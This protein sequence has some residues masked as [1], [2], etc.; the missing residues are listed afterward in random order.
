LETVIRLLPHASADGPTNMAA[1]ETLVRSAAGGVASLRLYGWT[2]ATVT[3]GYFQP[4][5][6]RLSDSRLANLP[7]VRRP[8]GGA[9]LVHDHEVT[10]CL[11]LPAGAPWQ[12]GEPWMPRMHRIITQA[13]ARLDLAGR[14]TPAGDAPAR[15]SDVLCFQQHTPGDLLSGM[16][17]V[18][19]SAQRKYHQALMQHGSILLAQ[20]EFTPSLPGIRELTGIELTAAQVQEAIVRAF[21]AIT[22]WQIEAADWRYGETEMIDN[23]ARDKYASAAWNERR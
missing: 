16:S 3:L 17:K 5:A 15:H 2:Q 1:D 11:A 10:Y 19:G 18:V 22:G 14:I 12:V 13:L 7:W 8:S 4:A 6:V 9:T 23:L 21:A 20:S